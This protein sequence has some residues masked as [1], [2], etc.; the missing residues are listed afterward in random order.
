MNFIVGSA[1]VIACALMFA[2]GLEGG[3]QSPTH[4]GAP[5]DTTSGSRDSLV[6]FKNDISP[7]ISKYCLPCHAE[8]E[9]NPS[10]LSLDT[11]KDLMDGGKHGKPVIPGDAQGSILVKKL[12]ADPPFG[13]PMPLKKRRDPE[14]KFLPPDLIQTIGR[15]IS[16]GA[17]DN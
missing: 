6:S 4:D 11:Y 10:E 5:A 9:Y 2:A 17:K 1:V 15:W 7:I 16:Q 14:Q 8:D 3:V 13:H 12:G